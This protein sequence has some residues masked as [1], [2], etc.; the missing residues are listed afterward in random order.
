MSTTVSG[1]PGAPEDDSGLSPEEGAGMNWVV[2]KELAVRAFS[3]R[4]DL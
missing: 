3:S 1:V 2:P 4:A